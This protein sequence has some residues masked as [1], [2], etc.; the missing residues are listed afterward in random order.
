MCA[1]APSRTQALVENRE[2]HGQL[3]DKDEQLE[4]AIEKQNEMNELLEDA[5]DENE[6]LR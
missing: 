6:A 4:I 3:D 2:L 1:R 5:E